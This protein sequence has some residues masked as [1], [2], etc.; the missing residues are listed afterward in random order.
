MYTTKQFNRLAMSMN[1]EKVG[2]IATSGEKY[3][4]KPGAW[5]TRPCGIARM[6]RRC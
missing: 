4:D 3:N 2:Y 1:N 5:A 6:R